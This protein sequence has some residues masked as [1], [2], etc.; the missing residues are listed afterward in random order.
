[1]PQRYSAVAIALHWSVAALILT[2]L[3][4]G[5]WMTRLPPGSASQFALY[6]L[7][8]SIGV[9]VLLLTA[10]RLAWRLFHR[11]P[12][13]PPELGSWE[14]AA[15]RAAHAG[16]YALTVALPLT[17]WAMVSAS[18][19]NL[20]TIL[21][22]VV[23]WPHL[24]VLPDLANKAAAEAALKSAHAAGAWAMLALV[25]LH[26]GAALKHHFALRDDVLARMLPLPWRRPAP[27]GEP[28]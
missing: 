14:R 8:K 5:L 20:P 17:G 9:T 4:M 12:P 2:L 3:A 7:H 10:L 24:P 16:L 27:S 26:I 23:P 13:L 11:P 18:P 19:W 6:Q 15:A 28:S 22:G 25:A 1:M 21:Y